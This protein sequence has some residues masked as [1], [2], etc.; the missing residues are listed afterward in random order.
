MPVFE[1]E[2]PEIN[3]H[4]ELAKGILQFANQV[5]D[6][7]VRLYR[8]GREMMW[9]RPDFTV[10]DAQAVIDAMGAN[11]IPLFTL[12]A[13]LGQFINLKYPGVLSS[14]DL[15]A[16][17]AYTVVNGRIVLDPTAK[18]PTEPEEIIEE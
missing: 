8:M 2:T 5:G 11:A 17:I 4:E 18:Y 1:I 15:D 14:E 9:K 16:P 7:L 6:E 3:Q 13:A 10:V 12:S